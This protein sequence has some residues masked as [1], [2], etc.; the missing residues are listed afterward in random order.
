VRA[1][2]FKTADA[3]STGSSA[4]D[5]RKHYPH[6]Q[7]IAC[8]YIHPSSGGLPAPK[9]DVL[10]ED[11]VNDG[12]AWRYGDMGALAPDPDPAGQLETIVVHAAGVPALLDPDGGS[13]FIWKVVPARVGRDQ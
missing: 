1:T 7:T 8:K 4:L 6:Y 12:I 11:A 5:L 2:R 10:C 3:C 13:R 9:H